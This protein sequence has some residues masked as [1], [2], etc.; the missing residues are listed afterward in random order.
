MIERLDV[1]NCLDI[2]ILADFHN[3]AISE[4]LARSLSVSEVKCHLSAGLE[5]KD[6]YH[7]ALLMDISHSRLTATLYPKKIEDCL[8][9]DSHFLNAPAVVILAFTAD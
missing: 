5:G 1:E 2:L 3:A 4:S 8:P 9:L 7:P 6:E